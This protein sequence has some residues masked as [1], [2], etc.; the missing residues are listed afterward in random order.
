MSMTLMVHR[1]DETNTGHA[2]SIQAN[3]SRIER[4]EACSIF[5]YN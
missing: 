1:S 3:W 5:V 2:I 4:F